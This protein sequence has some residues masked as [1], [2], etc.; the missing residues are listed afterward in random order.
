MRGQ[1]AFL[2][3]VPAARRM[4]SSATLLKPYLYVSDV[5]LLQKRKEQQEDCD[6]TKR[7]SRMWS[8][9]CDSLEQLRKRCRLLCNNAQ[10]CGHRHRSFAS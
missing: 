3:V 2:G 4:P 10:V 6:A 1:V 8:C 5:S 7:V 9:L